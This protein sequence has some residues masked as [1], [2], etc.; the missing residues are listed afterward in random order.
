MAITKQAKNVTIK[1][2]D[3]YQLFVGGKLQ[4]ISNTVNMESVKENLMLASNKKISA[5]GNK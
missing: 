4:K 5:K 3:R 1:V 2:K